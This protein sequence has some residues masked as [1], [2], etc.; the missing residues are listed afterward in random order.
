MRPS[1]SRLEADFCFAA[2]QRIQSMG[3]VCLCARRQRAACFA[4]WR[5]TERSRQEKTRRV[6]ESAR[7]NAHDRGF[8]V[9]NTER[10]TEAVEEETQEE[11]RKSGTDK[12]ARGQE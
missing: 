3:M 8:A 11:F 5:G 6:F 12:D 10:E 2:R 4:F 1:H 7:G 9:T